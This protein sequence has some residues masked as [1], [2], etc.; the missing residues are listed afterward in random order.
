MCVAQKNTLLKEMKLSKKLFHLFVVTNL[1]IFGFAASAVADVVVVG[2][3]PE[4]KMTEAGYDN[5]EP[6]LYDV[7]PD[8]FKWGVATA[9]SEVYPLFLSKSLGYNWHICKGKQIF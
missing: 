5:E 1:T 2:L 6:L 9:A 8:G 3:N 7:F 4:A